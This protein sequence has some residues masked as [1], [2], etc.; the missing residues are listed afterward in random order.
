MY[1]PYSSKK[2]NPH[3]TVNKVQVHPDFTIAGSETYRTGAGVPVVLTD[4]ARE[5][6]MSKKRGELTSYQLGLYLEELG[7]YVVENEFKPEFYN[8]EIFFY[9]RHYQRGAIIALRRDFKNVLHGTV[10]VLVTV[11]PYGKTQPIKQSTERVVM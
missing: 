9:S 6:A 2:H 5:R 11:Y 1:N 8:Q 4:H 3:S 7:K 10:L